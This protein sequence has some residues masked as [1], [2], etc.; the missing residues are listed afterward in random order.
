MLKECYWL[1][2]HISERYP[3]NRLLFTCGVYQPYNTIIA[4]CHD[5]T[6]SIART[7]TCILH[8][9]RF[10]YYKYEM[11]VFVVSKKTIQ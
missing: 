5:P 4:F 1:L 11:S 6:K 7:V 8:A 3:Q 9:I 2:L 10:V